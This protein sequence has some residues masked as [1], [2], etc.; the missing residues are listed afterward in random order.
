MI[1]DRQFKDAEFMSA[2]D[3]RYVLTDWQD[4]IVKGFAL[5]AFTDELYHHLIQHCSFIAHSSRVGFWDT[6]FRNPDDTLRFVAQ[7]DEWQG[8]ISVEYG[9]TYW[10]RGGNSTC[11]EYYDIN[12]AM[13]E[14][15]QPHLAKLRDSL[16]DFRLHIAESELISAKLRVAKL[17]SERRR[18]KGEI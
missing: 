9:D 4:F 12:C 8:C 10:I 13:V 14:V 3:K 6:Y 11:A 1:R 5:H 18:D 7:F 17:T 15:L 2:K 16:K